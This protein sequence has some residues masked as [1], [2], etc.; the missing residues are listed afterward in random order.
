[1]SAIEFIEPGLQGIWLTNGWEVVRTELGDAIRYRS[2]SKLMDAIALSLIR[3][4]TRLQPGEFRWLRR[5]VELS[6]ADLATLLG[7]DSQTVSLIERGRLPDALVD[8]E[9]RRVAAGRLEHGAEALGSVHELA[10]RTLRVG[11]VT[12]VGSCD[13]GRWT[14]SST[15]REEGA[16][17]VVFG[18]REVM[19]EPRPLLRDLVRAEL[20]SS[21]WIDAVSVARSV[22][23][24]VSTESEMTAPAEG[25]I[26]NPIASSRARSRHALH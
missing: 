11:P 22:E 4:P 12:T 23:Q 10:S 13:N 1:M 18:A 14:F 21:G 24:V 7:R 3:K 6:Q 8:R 20:L 17:V 2:V 9:L 25:L 5:H 15:A 19:R 26:W 16:V